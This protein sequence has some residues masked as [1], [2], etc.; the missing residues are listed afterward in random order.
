MRKFVLTVLLSA[1]LA[2][3]LVACS[4]DDEEAADN[5]EPQEVYVKTEEVKKEDL[6]VTKDIY[7]RLSP[8][9]TTPVMLQGPGELDQLKVK[10]GD[11][12]KKDDHL[13]TVLT[14]AGEQKITANKAGTIASLSASEG[15]MLSES[16]PLLVITDMDDVIVDVNVTHSVR[17]LLKV[18]DKAEATIEG[19]SYDAKI[20]SI[21]S[22]P[23][24]TGLFP[25]KATIKN[26]D[27]DLVAGMVAQLS[28]QEKRLKKALLVPTE[29]IVEESDRAFVYIIKHNV[30]R[31]VEVDIVESQTDVTA[32]E[33]G[34]EKG[35]EIVVNGQ[36][37]LYDEAKV[38]IVED[39]EADDEEENES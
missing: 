10:N 25:V 7:G 24:D 13:A 38:V 15:D 26:K 14:Q 12:V 19:E 9:S 3:F 29:S 28:I 17:D 5:E 32:V 16:D 6:K 1:C 33:G 34:V 8:K 4:D 18:D 35:D 27:D 36:L 30:A 39:E 37:T 20:T 11:E 2:V 21:D 31:E 22:V 23:D